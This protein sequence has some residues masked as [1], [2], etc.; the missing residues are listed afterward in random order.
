MGRPGGKWV[1]GRDEG[2]A[3]G[4]GQVAGEWDGEVVRG[5]RQARQSREVVEV[6]TGWRV[7]WRVLWRG[8]GGGIQS[9]WRAARPGLVG[10]V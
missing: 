4:R 3:S 6:W 8:C 1:E 9:G 5:L 2:V 10:G 7:L